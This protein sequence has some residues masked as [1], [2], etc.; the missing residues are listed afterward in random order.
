MALV[1]RI[2]IALSMCLASSAFAQSTAQDVEAQKSLA[3]LQKLAREIGELQGCMIAAL[4]DEGPSEGKK[5]SPKL[6]EKEELFVDELDAAVQRYAS[7]GQ[8]DPTPK[9]YRYRLWWSA[10]REGEKTARPSGSINPM[11]C[12]S[13]R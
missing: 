12:R 9:E 13:L 8:V 7:K 1:I 2:G 4:V 3:F 10:I 11:E 5:Y 6:R